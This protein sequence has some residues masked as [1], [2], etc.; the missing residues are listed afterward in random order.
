MLEQ[1]AATQLREGVSNAQ[2]SEEMRALLATAE[3]SKLVDTE[4]LEWAA[5]VIDAKVKEETRLAKLAQA[6]EERKKKIAE[7]EAAAKLA[8]LKKKRRHVLKGKAKSVLQMIGA[9]QRGTKERLE[10]EALIAEHR[11]AL[12]ELQQLK[13][14]FAEEEELELAKV[15]EEEERRKEQLAAL[16]LMLVLRIVLQ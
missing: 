6:E 16:Q 15:A 14:E 2:T 10:E 13:E 7:E 12:E 8:V 1:D 9:Q 11:S 4:V 5:Y 3:K